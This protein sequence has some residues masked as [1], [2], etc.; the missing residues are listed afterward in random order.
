MLSASMIYGKTKTHI[1][2]VFF[3]STI[4]TGMWKSQFPSQS[5][6]LLSSVSPSK[7]EPNTHRVD[8]LRRLSYIVHDR[9]HWWPY[10]HVIVVVF[11]V[12][13]P[14]LQQQLH[15]GVVMVLVMIV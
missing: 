5:T 10:R 8:S 15:G 9:D 14:S 2:Y 7:T 12:D 11:P 1:F 13:E 3:V 6:C 4:S